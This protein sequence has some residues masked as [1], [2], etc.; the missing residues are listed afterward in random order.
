[1]TRRLTGW[2]IT[3]VWTMTG[4]LSVAPSPCVHHGAPGFAAPNN[5][6][7]P[8]LP[9]ARD[10][11][12]VHSAHADHASHRDPIGPAEPTASDETPGAPHEGH[13]APCDCL[14]DCC[15]AATAPLPG[16]ADVPFAAAQQTTATPHAAARRE[17]AA[18]LDLR[19]PPATA[20]PGAR[21]S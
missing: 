13:G 11:H 21:D 3:F 6:P 2:L 14:T 5:A 9:D 16:R 1:M 10:S 15:A 12:A 19:Q 17:V 20:P 7:R 18:R 8:H 4:L